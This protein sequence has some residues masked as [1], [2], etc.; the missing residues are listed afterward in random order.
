MITKERLLELE[1]EI[2]VWN[3]DNSLEIPEDFFK[4]SYYFPSGWCCVEFYKEPNIDKGWVNQNGEYLKINGKTKFFNVGDFNNGVAWVQIGSKYTF[5]KPD[6]T[7][8]YTGKIP[9]EKTCKFNGCDDFSNGYAWVK[10]GS[11]YTFIKPN[12]TDLYTGKIPIKDT[13]KFD[14]CYD[15][16]NGLA[17]VKIGSSEYYINILGFRFNTNDQ[18]T[19]LELNKE[20][21]KILNKDFPE[22]SMK[23]YLLEK[24]L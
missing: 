17:W 3:G 14:M 22:N 7:D 10:I 4:D 13:C 16:S 15:F 1:K 23:H 6:G 9:T 11:K 8:L 2:R 12:V 19:A 20:F 18:A 24:F 21:L 5:I